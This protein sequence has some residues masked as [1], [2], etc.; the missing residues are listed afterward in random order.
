MIMKAPS[1]IHM[2]SGKGD[3]LL[4]TLRYTLKTNEWDDQDGTDTPTQCPLV[5]IWKFQEDHRYELQILEK[6]PNREEERNSCRHTWSDASCCRSPDDNVTKEQLLLG[7]EAAPFNKLSNTLFLPTDRTG[8]RQQ[9]YPRL[10][11]ARRTSQIDPKE[12]SMGGQL[13]FIE[14]CFL[15][16]LPGT[17][18]WMGVDGANSQCDRHKIRFRAVQCTRFPHDCYSFV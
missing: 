2:V 10:G 13:G 9:L 18:T 12:G 5:F 14:P 15:A 4:S 11:Y 7:S 16:V 3:N 6:V 8:R 17:F 1:V